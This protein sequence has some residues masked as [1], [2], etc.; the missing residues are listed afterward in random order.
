MCHLIRVIYCKLFRG[1]TIRQ[2]YIHIHI[3]INYISVYDYIL[4]HVILKYIFLYPKHFFFSI[5]TT[6]KYLY[7]ER[8]T[9]RSK[10]R[11][12]HYWKIK[13]KHFIRRL[14]RGWHWDSQKTTVEQSFAHS[15]QFYLSKQSTQRLSFKSKFSK[16]EKRIKNLVPPSKKIVYSRILQKEILRFFL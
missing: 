16:T 14:F 4:L 7:V 2:T 6:V 15:V 11:V 13:I 12:Q 1:K 10:A 5:L 8:I 3:Y 9:V